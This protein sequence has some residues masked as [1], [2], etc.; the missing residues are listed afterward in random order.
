M[1]EKQYIQLVDIWG[2]FV[3]EFVEAY[4]HGP[5]NIPMYNFYNTDR[6]VYCIKQTEAKIISE[7]EY[8]VAR[9][10]GA[11]VFRGDI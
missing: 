3:A 2:G 1:A 11:E 7:K 10:A 5:N 9:L 6:I 4:D 8:F